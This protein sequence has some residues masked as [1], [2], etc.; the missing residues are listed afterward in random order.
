MADGL[1]SNEITDIVSA[2]DNI[3]VATSRGTVKLPEKKL[4]HQ[5]LPAPRMEEVRINGRPV[6]PDSIPKL[7]HDKNNLQITF[8]TI[9]FAQKGRILYRYRLSPESGWSTTYDRIV[10]FPAMAAGTYQFEVQAQNSDRLWGEAAF[11]TITIRPFIG[12]TWWFRTLI[13]LTALAGVL[14]LYRSRI[15]KL[16]RIAHEEQ[17]RVELEREKKELEQLTLQAQINPHFL[18][19]S[20]NAIQGLIVRGEK[21]EAMRYLSDFHQLLRKTLDVSH[22]PFVTLAED[23]TL[24][25]QYLDL[26]KM[27]FESRFQY[28]IEI[29]DRVDLYKTEVPPMLIQPFVENA[30][31]HAFPPGEISRPLI[32]IEYRLT[33]CH[34]EITVTDNGIGISESRRRKNHHSQSHQAYG[35]AIPEKRLALLDNGTAHHALSV[36]DWKTDKETIG[37]TQVRIRLDVAKLTTE[38]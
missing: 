21:L 38:E 17:Q 8:L 33:D 23:V 27:R 16:K 29:D 24:L 15:K 12:Q 19:N 28:S 3:W 22:K 37:G 30:V 34:L 7:A 20:L 25:T 31:L 5:P 6:H 13:V 26:E 32:K 10:N 18:A 11:L 35:L 1:P 14:I 9:D 36:S 4:L 2:G